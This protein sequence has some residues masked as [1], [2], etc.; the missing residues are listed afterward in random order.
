MWGTE[1]VNILVSYT[2]NKSS[3]TLWHKKIPTSWSIVLLIGVEGIDTIII[4]SIKSSIT[5]RNAIVRS[6]SRLLNNLCLTPGCLKLD[7]KFS[8]KF[9]LKFGLKL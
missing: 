8:F 6:T 1:D 7:L 9:C 2:E 5:I 3:K 4:D